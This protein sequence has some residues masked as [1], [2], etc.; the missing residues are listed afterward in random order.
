MD[1]LVEEQRDLVN[2][3]ILE[4]SNRLTHDH[5]LSCSTKEELKRKIKIDYYN[6]LIKLFIE[7]QKNANNIIDKQIKIYI[8]NKNRIINN[9]LQRMLLKKQRIL[10]RSKTDWNLIEEQYRNEEIEHIKILLSFKPSDDI[11]YIKRAC[12]ND[13]RLIRN[14]IR[15][16][17]FNDDN[18]YDD[19]IINK[20][21][22]LEFKLNSN[23]DFVVIETIEYS[24]NN[25]G[26]L[27]N[28]H[29]YFE[30]LII[31]IID[32]NNT[33]KIDIIYDDNFKKFLLQKFYKKIN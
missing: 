7:K 8:D 27:I 28:K 21:R 32:D 2:Q 11:T 3:S 15:T 14:Y 5:E 10:E 20:Y 17:T 16:I 24:N 1:E 18:L 31:K 9:R 13:I 6:E 23:E 19:N 12:Y 30:Q 22:N 25:Y 26:Y 29:N 33:F 4:A